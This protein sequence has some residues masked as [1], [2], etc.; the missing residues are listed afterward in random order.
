MKLLINFALNR[1]VCNTPVS[2]S[3][4]LILEWR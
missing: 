1:I 2:S 3:L 4:G